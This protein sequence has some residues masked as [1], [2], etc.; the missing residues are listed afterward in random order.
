MLLNLRWQ[1]RVRPAERSRFAG[2]T[3]SLETPHDLGPPLRLFC[4]QR[5]AAP[6]ATAAK[7]LVKTPISMT[8]AAAATCACTNSIFPQIDR[9]RY[10]AELSMPRT[11]TPAATGFSRLLVGPRCWSAVT[12]VATPFRP[13]R[14]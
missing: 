5:L 11:S 3:A 8:G 2:G 10:A 14:L 1:K 13:A 9:I 6:Q 7:G 4:G 12:P